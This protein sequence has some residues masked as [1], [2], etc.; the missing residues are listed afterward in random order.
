MVW[1]RVLKIVRSKK[2]YQMSAVAKSMLH[3]GDNVNIVG[4]ESSR[5]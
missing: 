5:T 2:V 1:W 3:S 4:H